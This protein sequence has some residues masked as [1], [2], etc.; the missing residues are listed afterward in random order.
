MKRAWKQFWK[1]VSALLSTILNLC[2]A[3]EITSKGVKDD[4]E[5]GNEK[6]EAKREKKRA[7]WA[8]NQP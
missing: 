3:A 6:A 2:L 8:T 1:A 4:A 7:A 5:F